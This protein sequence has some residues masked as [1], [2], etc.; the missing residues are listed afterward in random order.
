MIR[1]KDKNNNRLGAKLGPD[2]SSVPMALQLYLTSIMLN[3]STFYMFPETWNVAANELSWTVR[4]V[5][6]T[7]EYTTN[8]KGVVDFMRVTLTDKLDLRPEKNRGIAYAISTGI[9]GGVW[10]GILGASP[11]PVT[12]SWI[13][14]GQ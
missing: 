6:L 3:T 13:Y 2:A 5:D 10:H 14:V 9:T 1:Y 7:L 8:N 11:V 12:A 4:H